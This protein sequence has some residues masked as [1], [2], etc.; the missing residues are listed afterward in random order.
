[1]QRPVPLTRDLVL[2]GGGHTHALVLRKWGMKTLPGVR[3]TLINPAPTATYTGMLPGLIAGHYDRDA[4]E[5]DLVRLSRF[6]GARLLVG[7]VTGIDRAARRIH[8]AGHPSLRY[9]IVSLD[10]GVTSFMPEIPGF[11][12]H[13][14]AA[15]PLGLYSRA[16]LR[17]C[18]AVASGQAEASVA[19][20]GGGVAG[21]EL[22]LAMQHRLAELGEA[23]KVTVIEAEEALQG[24]SGATRP[25]LFERLFRAGVR[26]IEGEAV[27]RI[28][29]NGVTT[30][31]GRFVPCAITVGAGGARPHPWVADLGLDHE[32][33]YLTVDASLRSVSDPRIFAV[34]DCAHLGFAPRPKAG[35]YA[36]RAA[37]VLEQNLRAAL[38]GGRRRSFRP[39][40]DYLKLISLGAKDA[41]ADRSG[42]G[43]AGPMWWRLKDRIDRAFMDKFDRYPPM[44]V[45]PLPYPRAKGVAEAAGSQP[46]CAGCGG[47]V[48]PGA[49]SAALALLP[50]TQRDDVLSRPGDDAAILRTG[51]A[52]QV[53]T[54][55]HLRAFTEDPV[56]FARIAT[57]HALGDIWAMGAAP[58]AAVASV[59]LPHMNPDMAQATLAEMLEAASCALR[60]EGA[61][62]VGGHT[63]FGA[64]MTFGLTI[65][66]ICEAP[67]LTLSGARPGDALVLTRPIGSG[68]LLAAEMRLKARGEDVTEALTFMSQ[69]QSGAAAVLADAGARAM[70]DV[71]GF[72]LAGHL[73][74][75]CDASGLAACVH[76]KAIPV[77]AGAED[78]AA[79]GVRS[80]LWSQNRAALAGRIDGP[81]DAPRGALLFDPQTSGGLLAVLPAGVADAAVSDLQS[82]G[83]HAARIGELTDAPPA[84]A[85]V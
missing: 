1:M 15:K 36:V 19:V 31:A 81:L 2:I 52:T 17:H 66:G 11:L 45:E 63:T 67:P 33:G 75:L 46:P 49:L 23:P 6:A 61:E 7:R 8:V 74:N 65:T 20:I 26:I 58:Q 54:T 62:I 39:Q 56:A 44:P 30:S 73:M 57:V 77:Y 79:A 64:E 13:A 80:T 21:V 37:P 42:F 10:I 24:V 12:D 9:D 70:T 43:A 84:I 38:A 71:T 69:S 85:V 32:D 40:R 18:A 25:I 16:W 50:E 4:L 28:D 83:C 76:L 55:D 27:V 47:K 48:G 14:V 29:A 78:L 53:L 3:V 34:G 41:V 59:I 60:A 72:G 68:T 22:A 5:M 51:G 82:M 35:V